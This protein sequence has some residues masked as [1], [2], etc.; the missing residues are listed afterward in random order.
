MAPAL[1]RRKTNSTLLLL[2]AELLWSQ[3]ILRHPATRQHHPVSPSRKKNG[4]SPTERC[5][6]ERGRPLIVPCACRLYSYLT[7][8]WAFIARSADVPLLVGGKAVS[9]SG[10]CRHFWR[11][12]LCR[13]CTAASCPIEYHRPSC[14]PPHPVQVAW[15]SC[16]R[17]D[18]DITE[19]PTL[20]WSTAVHG[21]FRRKHPA[22]ATEV[23]ELLRIYH[24]HHRGTGR[25]AS[26]SGDAVDAS[27]RKSSRGGSVLGAFACCTGQLPH[28]GWC[29]T[30]LTC[31]AALNRPWDAPCMRR[32]AHFL[33]DTAAGASEPSGDG[34]MGA[35]KEHASGA[36][37]ADTTLASEPS[38]SD[39][40]T[41]SVMGHLPYDL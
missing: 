41:A 14:A 37:P 5:G 7:H 6:C 10:S 12:C 35:D 28:E 36:Q 2:Q 29:R 34:A 20:P 16:E 30:R 4:N 17:L 40:A 1:L 8:P 32:C 23:Q 15:A 31:C 33:A 38:C 13:T 24:S 27:T 18:A 11:C 9:T 19:A 21:Q 25:R 26:N 22:F 39:N 3:S